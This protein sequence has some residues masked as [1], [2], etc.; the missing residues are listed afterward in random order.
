VGAGIVGVC[1]ALA[2]QQRGFHVKI[3]DPLGPGQACS[4]GNAGVITPSAFP[5]AASAPL[6]ALPRL[7]LRPASPAA[8]HFPSALALAPWFLQFVRATGAG[9]LQRDTA[10]LHGLGADALRAYRALLGEDLPHVNR[11]GYLIVHLT[12]A[13][14]EAARRFDAIREALG[15]RVRRLDAPELAALEPVFAGIGVGGT[16]VE[17]AAHV[18]DPAAFTAALFD[19][20]LRRGGTYEADEVLRIERAGDGGTR[21]V[22]RGS[23]HQPARAVL[24]AGAHTNRLLASAG[25]RIPLIAERGYHADLAPQAPAVTRPVAVPALGAVLTPTDR[26]VRFAGLSHFGLPGLPPRAQLMESALRRLGG[27]A[28]GAERRPGAAIWSGERPATPDSLPIVERVAGFDSLFVS[29]GHGHMGLT[30]AAVTGQ[31]VADMACGVVPPLSK[32]LSSA[33]FA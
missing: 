20:F 14:R 31:M 12:E 23:L 2:L 24:A 6:A 27:I 13:E 10:T 21:L 22:G 5:L 8:L 3:I 9:R 26:G 18:P 1:A 11:R 25:L 32:P 28:H 7:F 30:L 15:A 17:D 33:R 4:F 19:V 29:T 16:L